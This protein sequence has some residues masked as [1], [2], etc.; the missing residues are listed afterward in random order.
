MYKF[1]KMN[2]Q[3]KHEI[4]L[5]HKALAAI[6]PDAAAQAMLHSLGK[7]LRENACTPQDAADII[8]GIFDEDIDEKICAVFAEDFSSMM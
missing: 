2:E 6:M 3:E 5:M 4:I 8:E 7:F 1:S